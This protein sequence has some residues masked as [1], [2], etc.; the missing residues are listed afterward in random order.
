MFD[1]C[2]KYV[3]N[4][5]VLQFLMLYRSA[6]I[7][8]ILDNHKSILSNGFIMFFVIYIFYTVNIY[9]AYECVM[10][11]IYFNYFYPYFIHIVINHH[12][13]RHRRRHH[14]HHHHHFHHELNKHLITQGSGFELFKLN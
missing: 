3:W 12:H 11:T 7:M 4:N 5:E 9:D 6:I 10:N 2:D 1:T 13:H 14:H 8:D